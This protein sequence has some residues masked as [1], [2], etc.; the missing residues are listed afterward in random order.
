[1]S[2]GEVVPELLLVAPADDDGG[3]AGTLQQPGERDLRLGDA[4]VAAA[5]RRGVAAVLPR[6]QAAGGRA[7]DEEAWP[8]S[9][10]LCAGRVFVRSSHS[11]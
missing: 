2:S 4:D 6:E 3:D 7:P 9:T 10:D 8:G 11:V 1:M 5:F